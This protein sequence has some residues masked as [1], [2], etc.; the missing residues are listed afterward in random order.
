M[1]LYA[2]YLAAEFKH[3]ESLRHILRIVMKQSK[4]SSDEFYKTEEFP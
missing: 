1:T 4:N 3:K 2:L